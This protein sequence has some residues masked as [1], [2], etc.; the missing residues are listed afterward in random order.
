[1][2]TSPSPTSI[3]CAAVLIAWRPE[4][5]NRLT[6]RPPT[7]TGKSARS[8]AIRATFRLSSPAW[9]AQPR[10]TSS[11]IG[12]ATPP[13]GA[14]PFPRAGLVGT[15]EDDVLEEGGVAAGPPPHGWE[16]ARREIVR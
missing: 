15:P 11:T 6:V 9:F 16:D 3:A 1:M 13:R 2:N 12:G 5:H 4:P 8:S 10:M 7:S 14:F